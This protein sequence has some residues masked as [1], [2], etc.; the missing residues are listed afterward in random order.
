MRGK[1][2][3]TQPP[4]HDRRIKAA[5]LADPGPAF[6]GQDSFPA[7]KAPIQLWASERGGPRAQVDAIERGLPAPHEYHVVGNTGRAPVG[8]HLIF[9]LCPPALAQV[10]PEPCTDAPGFDRA[11]FHKQFNA[12][13]LAFF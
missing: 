13:V 7:V 1:P 2:L 6:F 12:D 3:P 9:F 4:V 11:A 10:N 8:G 5:V